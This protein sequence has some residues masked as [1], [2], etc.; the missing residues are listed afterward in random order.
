MYKRGEQNAV[1]LKGEKKG[2][3]ALDMKH[4]IPQAIMLPTC[5]NIQYFFF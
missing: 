4:N 5:V 3:G 2:G 1:V